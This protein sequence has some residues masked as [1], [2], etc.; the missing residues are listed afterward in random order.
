MATDRTNRG[1]APKPKRLSVCVLVLLAAGVLGAGIAEAATL[2]VYANG[3]VLGPGGYTQTSGW[4]NRDWNA[5][6]RK[7]NSGQM[8]VAYYDTNW[9][10]TTYSGVIY[11]NCNTLAK[12]EISNNGYFVSR[13]TNGGT[14]SFPVY[15]E[16]TNGIY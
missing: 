1:G 9:T 16:T 15:C 6:C 7:D 14:V 4:N 5:A 10:R 13:C 3:L 8:S 2:N 11:T 12:V